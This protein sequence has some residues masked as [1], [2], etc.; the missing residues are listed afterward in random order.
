MSLIALGVYRP[1]L[2]T[3]LLLYR[4]PAPDGFLSVAKYTELPA[5]GFAH[6]GCVFPYRG[7][8][9]TEIQME[10]K[11]LEPTRRVPLALPSSPYSYGDRM[12]YSLGCRVWVQ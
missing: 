2:K 8:Q 12:S 6:M 3:V 4:L 9:M 5:H 1:K 10:T 11:E 7:G